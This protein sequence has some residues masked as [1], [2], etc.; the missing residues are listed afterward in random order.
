MGHPGRGTASARALAGLEGQKEAHD[1]WW[2]K[3]EDVEGMGLQGLEVTA[4]ARLLFWF[5]KL[6]AKWTSEGREQKHWK[7]R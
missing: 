3:Q 6:P 7:E 1:S 5:Q 4:G 2:S